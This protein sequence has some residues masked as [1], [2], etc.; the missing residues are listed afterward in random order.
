MTGDRT[1][2][3]GGCFAE[4]GQA[5]MNQVDVVRRERD[6][7]ICHSIEIGAAPMWLHQPLVG[8]PRQAFQDVRDFM[9]EDVPKD[10]APQ[11]LLASTRD[12]VPED[13][14]SASG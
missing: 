8:M 2:V 3:G 4:G 14:N 9:G 6:R 5:T 12:A 13:M 11:F 1:R 7:P 10:V